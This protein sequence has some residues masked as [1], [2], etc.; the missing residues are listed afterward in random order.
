M[1]TNMKR[2]IFCL[3]VAIPSLHSRRS[4]DDRDPFLLGNDIDGADLQ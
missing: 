4:E 1:G 3:T 2:L